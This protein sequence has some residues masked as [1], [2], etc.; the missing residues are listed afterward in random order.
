MKTV[1]ILSNHHLYTYNLRKEVIQSLLDAGFRVVVR[2]PYGEKVEL[3]KDMGC[4]FID[5]DLERRGT[6]PIHDLGLFLTYRR[7]LSSVKPDIVLTYTVK[8]NLYGGLACR[9]R[10]IP[11]LANIT[12]L[13]TAVENESPAQ[14]MIIWMYR[15]AFKKVACVFFQNTANYRFFVDHRIKLKNHR[16]IPGSGV[17]LTEYGLLEYPPDGEIHFL[18]IARVMKEKGIDQYLDSAKAIRES[19][20]VRCFTYWVFVR[21]HMKIRFPNCRKGT[22]FNITE[23][24]MI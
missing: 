12:G 22:L 7:I 14:K 6:N 15:I 24:R 20:P 18:F 2:V 13:G 10:H 19:I 23:C 1:L 4:G 9:M 5:V 8:P 17:N 21:K 11:C 3:L 16:I